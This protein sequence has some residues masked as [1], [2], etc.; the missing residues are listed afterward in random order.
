MKAPDVVFAAV[1]LLSVFGTLC[2]YVFSLFVYLSLLSHSASPSASLFVDCRIRG[3]LL[4]EWGSVCLC[5]ERR[6]WR[7]WCRAR[8]ELAA[9][10]ECLG[11]GSDAA[12]WLGLEVEGAYGLGSDRLA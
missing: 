12:L 2:Y 5:H 4:E 6:C 9:A 11:P 10:V 3:R 8:A 7:V 1:W